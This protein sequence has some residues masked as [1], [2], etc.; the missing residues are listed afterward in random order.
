MAT[1]TITVKN[2]P[3]QIESLSFAQKNVSVKKG[4]TLGLVVTVKP[5]ELSSSQLTWTS[6]D[7][8]IVTVDENGVIKGIKEGTATITVRSSNGKKNYILF[9]FLANLYYIYM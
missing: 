6:S 2:A 7:P 5:T 4:D 1:S 9:K 8:S 3:K